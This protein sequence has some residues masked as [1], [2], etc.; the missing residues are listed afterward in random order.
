MKR[1]AA[2]TEPPRAHD[3]RAMLAVAG[4]AIASSI[5]GLQNQFANDDIL[6][7]ETNQRVQDV[8]NWKSMFTLPYWPPPYSPDLYR[9]LLSL[10]HSFEFIVGAGAPIA[11]RITSYVLYAAAAV[12]V[13]RLLARWTSRNIAL[14]LALVFAAHPVHVEAVA[15]GVAQNEII[16][17]L[18][19]VVATGRYLDRRAHGT[20][21]RRDWL[22]LGALFVAACLFKEEGFVLPGLLLSAEML[23]AD[24][25]TRSRRSLTAGFVFLAALG[26]CVFLVRTAVLHDIAGTFV[27]PALVGLGA[28]RRGLTMLGIVPEWVRLL[29]WPFHLRADYSPQEFAAVE[30]ELE[31][32]K[33]RAS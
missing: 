20:L 24:A 5:A 17:A 28:Y 27:A 3:W 16:V 19:A 12:A 8:A 26:L 14:V 22:E 13:F 2:S 21:S 33:S 30:A 25:E 7:I 10:L 29:A 1:T 18:L 4:V 6:L 23:L 9:P 31:S 15:L 11:Y 32:P